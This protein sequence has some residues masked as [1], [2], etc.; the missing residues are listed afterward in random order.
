MS[1]QYID[2]LSEEVK[3]GMDQKAR[4]GKYPSGA[5]PI[6]Y[7]RNKISKEIEIDPDRS[8]K[9]RL[10]FEKY[11]EGDHSLSDILKYSKDINLKYTR[12]D[13]FLVK[14]EID[15]ILK[16]IFYTG[17]FEWKGQVLKG[18]HPQ[19]IDTVLFDKVQEV[20]NGR[21]KG[22][23]SKKEIPFRR[24]MQCGICNNVITA[25][26]KKQKYTYYH[27]TGYG[28]N[29]K[30]EYVPEQKIDSQFAK[31]VGDVT[32][33]YDWYDFFKSNIENDFSNK[34]I[35]VARERDRLELS[36]DTIQSDMRKS[37]KAKIDGLIDE[38][39][40]KSVYD[41]YQ[42]QLDS[43]NFRLSNLSESIDQKID[44]A[45]RTIELS[46]QA[47]S[48]YLKANTQQKRRL[49]KS[50]LSNCVLKDATLY[51]TYNKAFTII[52]EGLVLNIKRGGPHS[53]QTFVQFDFRVKMGYST[54]GGTRWKTI[55]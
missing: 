44:I 31:I 40:F 1:K 12:S 10:L 6:G 17:R 34:K 18:D 25:Q 36:R 43:I 14:A 4:Q 32:I 41:E 9:I 19:I 53:Q 15:R 55:E 21:A 35:Q 27:C 45:M 13:R 54:R 33:P 52:A 29:H 37:F 47:E 20:I 42:K 16:R 2:N 22:K 3:K 8:G 7:L 46:Y 28:S 38:S 5:I 23:M 48:L 51:P 30:I 11:L 26:I 24:L 50:V 39:F 49:L